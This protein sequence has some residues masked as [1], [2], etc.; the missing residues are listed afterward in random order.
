MTSLRWGLNGRVAWRST[1]FLDQNL[2]EAENGGQTIAFKRV[3][4]VGAGD[5][6]QSW[7]C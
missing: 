6:S 2:A 7:K 5:C 1:L 3:R 4:A